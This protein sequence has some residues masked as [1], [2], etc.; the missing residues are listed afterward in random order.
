[1]LVS[2]ARSSIDS[3]TTPGPA[4]SSTLPMALPSLM[5]GVAMMRRIRSLATTPLL[6]LPV[7]QKRTVSGTE[8]RMSLVYQ[9]LAMSVEP[10]PNANVPSA[11]AVHVWLSVPTTTS[12][13]SAMSS[14]TALWQMASLPEPSLDSS[15]RRMPWALQNS[16]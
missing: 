10:T 1:M 9:V 6:G 16:R 2:V 3:A 15:Y 13:G 7:T 14:R 11:P 5:N 8:T 4:N 12:P